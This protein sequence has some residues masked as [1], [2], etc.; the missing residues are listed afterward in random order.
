MLIF[1]LLVLKKNGVNIMLFGLI[2]Y[3]IYYILFFPEFKKKQKQGQNLLKLLE[4]YPGPAPVLARLFLAREAKIPR[5]HNMEKIKNP[6][7]ILCI[8]PL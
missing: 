1:I 7:F 3:S 8:N 5:I 2:I 6:V 4:Y